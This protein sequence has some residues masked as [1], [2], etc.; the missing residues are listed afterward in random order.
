MGEMRVPRDAYYAA[1]TQRAVE[2]FPISG[3][4]ESPAF[5][6][7][8]VI[9]KKAA[10]VANNRLGLLDDERCRA[11][12]EA[13]DEVLAGG[14]PDQFVVDVFQ[15]GA[16]TSFNMNVNEVLAGLADEKLGKRRGEKYVHPNDHVNMAQS[17]ND[18]F[19]T[20]MRIAARSELAKLL[21][22]VDELA[23]SFRTK[24]RE[25]DDIVKS[26]RTHLQDAVPVRLGQEFTA[27]AAALEK[28]R[29]EI[30]NSARSV[31]ELGIG[32]S[33][34]GT[35]LNTH[36]EYADAVIGEINRLTGFEF[37][38]S[39]DLREAMQSQMPVAHV[40]AALRLLA[41]EL[42][43]IANDLRL[44]SS[45]PTTGL[46]EFVLPPVQP[47]SSIMPGK[48]NPVMAEMLNMVAFQVIG[49]D[50]TISLA[51]QA[52]QMELNVMMPVMI[53]NLLMSIQILTNALD[54]FRKKCV[55]GITA[56]PER[57]SVPSPNLFSRKI[58]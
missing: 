19:P 12:V 58:C 44:M 41:Q 39:A 38:P 50:L 47:G 32:G 23:A 56:D 46:A 21:P 13:A 29:T 40:S 24:G 2:N 35:G 43:R 54:V 20:A 9:L 25:F 53:F 27:Y 28:A 36:P 16:G 10:S 49:S 57:C 33:A 55:D 22:V 30:A 17:T 14:Y 26:G 51:V 42:I 45:G 31:E 37:R 6:R 34:A 48:V 1:Q 5:I 11:I 4:R 15:A 8:F 18:A 3:M 7:A 52:G